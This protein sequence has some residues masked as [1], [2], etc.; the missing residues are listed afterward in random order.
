MAHISSYVTQAIP[1]RALLCQ[2]RHDLPTV[3]SRLVVFEHSHVFPIIV[4]IAFE[5]CTRFT[6]MSITSYDAM[7][8]IS[9]RRIA[10][11]DLYGRSVGESVNRV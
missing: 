1:N 6:Y 5:R 10:V 3:I 8:G 2:Q 11:A 4:L 9:P 7:D